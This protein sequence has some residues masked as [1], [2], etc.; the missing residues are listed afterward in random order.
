[1][2]EQE[3]GLTEAA[4]VL[5]PPV[6][7]GF[8]ALVVVVIAAFVINT[9]NLR[10]I[11]AK[12]GAVEHTY[13]VKGSLDRFLAT[14]LDAETSER[15]FVITGQPSYL[16]PFNQAIRQI[17]S[18]LAQLRTLMAGNSEQATDLDRLQADAEIKRRELAEVIRQRQEYGQS[19]AEAVVE[20]NVGKR[21]MD[22]MRAIVARMQAREDTLLKNRIDQA[23]RSYRSAVLTRFLTTGLALLALLLLFVATRR[24]G[25]DRLRVAEIA[26]R[27][28]VTLASIGDG[29]VVTDGSG[30]VTAVNPVGEL[31]TGWTDKDARGRPV[32]DVFICP[33]CK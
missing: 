29:V 19:A 7:A 22:T 28:R 32:Q 27:F 23:G 12:A 9:A 31:L 6:I 15:G 14:M 20:T 13:A 33:S 11:D 4:H 30:Y 3:R 2:F 17:P 24:S 25:L 26:E 8:A 21:T 10:D 18:E 1:M 16:E 5:A